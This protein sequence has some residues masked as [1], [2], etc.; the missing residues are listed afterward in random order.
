MKYPVFFCFIIFFEFDC[1]QSSFFIFALIRDKVH[2][3]GRSL[4]L[5]KKTEP[6]SDDQSLSDP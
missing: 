5:G 6:P 1:Q 4:E 2:F 3:I